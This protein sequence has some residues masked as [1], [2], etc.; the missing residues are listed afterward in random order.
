[1]NDTVT[2]THELSTAPLHGERVTF[3]GTLASMTHA[4]AHEL[5]VQ[6]GGEAT[7]HI[8]RQSTLLVVGEEGWPLEDDGKPSVKLQLAIQFAKEGHNL[9]TIKESEWLQLIGFETERDDIHHLYTPATISR[10]VGVSVHVV[11]GW[12]RVGLIIPAKKVY[13]LPY[14]GF[15]EV[16]RARKLAELHNAGIDRN[17][18]IGSLLNLRQLLHD[19][20]WPFDKF[21]ILADGKHLLVR[22]DHSPIDP[23][24]R[25]RMFEFEAEQSDA[26]PSDSGMKFLTVVFAQPEIGTEVERTATDWF[27]EGCRLAEDDHLDAA[28]AAFR[29]SLATH[30]HD[31]E[32]HFHL[33]DCLYRLG[34]PNAALE[35][36]YA[37]VENDPNY[38]EA[39]TQIGCLLAEGNQ[40]EQAIAAFDQAL[41]LHDFAEAHIQK[42][43][44]LHQFHRTAEAIP[45]WEAYLELEFNG[46]WADVA[47]QRIADVE[48]MQ[49]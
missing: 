6:N 24:S 4:Q 3:T 42:A 38:L 41:L 12:E 40:C 45:H 39:W 5:V 13:R 47:K 19:A 29:E 35:R 10:L 37:A 44:V 27:I 31:S 23:R 14:F 20:D 28:V 21:D 2:H 8:S 43:E 49:D 11:R 34:K 16:T 48:S 18:I 1:M 25:Q 33:A 26:G 46:P 15:Q 7:G 36:Y 32:S 17:E 30:P 9:R 22:D